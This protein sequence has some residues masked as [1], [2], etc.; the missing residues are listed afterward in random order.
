MSYIIHSTNKDAFLMRENED[1]ISQVEITTDTTR[2]LIIE[3][4]S[5]AELYADSLNTFNTGF[6]FKAS[7]FP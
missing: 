6:T 7:K 3:D 5:K 4:K 2:V 1:G